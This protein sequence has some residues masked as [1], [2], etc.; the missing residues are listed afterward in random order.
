MEPPLGRAFAALEPAGLL[1]RDAMR[2]ANLDLRLLWLVVLDTGDLP[3]AARELAE[4]ARAEPDPLW[5][6]TLSPLY[7]T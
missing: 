7:G 6:L 4:E 3:A 2:G 1:K 5:D